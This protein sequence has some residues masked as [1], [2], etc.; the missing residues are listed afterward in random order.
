MLAEGWDADVITVS[1]NPLH[2]IA[3]LADPGNISGV[4]KHGTQLKQPRQDTP[5]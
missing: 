5:S 3:L 1:G 2:D 4:W